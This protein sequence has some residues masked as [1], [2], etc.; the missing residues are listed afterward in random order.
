VESFILPVDLPI[1]EEVVKAW[2]W[3]VGFKFDDDQ[4]YKKVITGEIVGVSMEWYR[5]PTQ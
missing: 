2:S 1:E 4:L 5:I 3:L